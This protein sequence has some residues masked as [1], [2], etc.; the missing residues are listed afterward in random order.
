VRSELDELLLRHSQ[1][2]G[3][4]VYEQTRVVDL[5]FEDDDE[6]RPIRPIGANYMR[7]GQSGYISFDYLIDA[8]GS[9]GIMSTK[10]RPVQLT[11]YLPTI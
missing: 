3:A 8:S 4:K 6:G 5:A 2:C 7:G 10:V 11:F 1:E 9:K